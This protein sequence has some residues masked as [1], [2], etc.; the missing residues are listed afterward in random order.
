[1]NIDD[2]VEKFS[3]TPFL[4]LGSGITRRYYNLPDWK[5]L[6]EHFAK[7]VR[8]DD[9]AYSA[10]ENKAIKIGNSAGLLPK[11]AELIQTD[12]DEKWFE[13]ASIRTV[14]ADILDKI[15][16]GLS[17]FKAEV[18]SFIKRKSCVVGKYE[19]EIQ[20]LS[21]L[22]VKNI[23]GVIT[24]NYD[25]FIEEQFHEYTR[26]VGQ[27]QLI[28]SAIQGVAEIYKIHGSVEAPESLIINEQDYLDFNR[29]SAY[30]A[31]KLMTIFMEYPI[32]FMGY[33]I[34]DSN[35]QK[36][37]RSIVD[38][39]DE[40]Q[41]R[42]LEDRFVFVEYQQ[43]RV[44]AEVSPYTIMINDKPLTMKKIVVD[45]FK[46]IYKALEGKKAKL[47]VRILRRFKQELYDFT[48]TSVPTA[49]MRVAS[50]EDDRVADEELVMAIGKYNDLGPRGLHG[51]EA[52]EWYRNIII[53]D[54]GCSADDL[55]EFA[56]DKLIKQ[57]SGRL[58]VNKY[59]SQA[60]GT[61]PRC[62]EAAERQDFD[63]IISK[64]IKK[65]CQRL[66][67]YT[68]V[69]QIW[70]NEKESLQRATDLIAYLPEN[71][72]NVDELESILKEIFNNDVN[73]L[74]NS[75]PA[76]RTNIRRLIM[77]YDYLKWGKT[78]ELSD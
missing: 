47:P 36:I 61:Y 16:T 72:M 7:E 59:L 44:G 77:I 23:A 15:K 56:F 63:F 14:D 6:L 11:V 21:A 41:I 51:L 10:Y 1:M 71:M 8:G 30:L 48:V 42:L 28:F 46:L 66:G 34:S 57:N 49:S 74:Q 58:P 29:N 5:G 76:I 17:P 31:A 54:I 39:L 40:E 33:S 50:I 13:D 60:T 78:K 24:T 4:F 25:T 22:S 20:M 18:A 68:S 75:I 27:K 70:A 19:S 53:D 38:C 12:Y 3:T 69:K 64:T 32:I 52:D 2:V 26:Y 35:I 43:G 37:I 65:N 67:G 62:V 55:L 73:V 9:F 45:D